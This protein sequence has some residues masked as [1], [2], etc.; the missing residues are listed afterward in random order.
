MTPPYKRS[1]VSLEGSE[2]RVNE[3]DGASVVSIALDRL[4]EG[5][6]SFGTAAVERVISLMPESAFDEA[7]ARRP[8]PADGPA[9]L[10]ELVE[11]LKLTQ[12]AGDEYDGLSCSRSLP[13]VFGG[14]GGGSVVG[15]GLRDG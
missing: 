10:Q 3:H 4:A 12:V 11:L 5:S 9:A 6:C 7:R 15:S 8:K 13:F 1:F 2:G 14:A